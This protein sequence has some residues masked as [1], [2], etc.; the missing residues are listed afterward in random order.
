MVTQAVG[1]GGMGLAIRDTANNN[2]ITIDNCYFY[3]NNGSEKQGG[4]G[5][6]KVSIYAINKTSSPYSNTIII[7][8][9]NL[10]GNIAIYGAGTSLFA[11]SR[12]NKSYTNILIFSFC[13]WQYNFSPISAAVDIAPDV[14]QQTD[15][16]FH[17]RTSP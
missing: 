9:C 17:C 13:T 3:Y 14:R 6:I 16:N 5:G 15:T 12:L 1:G 11:S 2:K 4:G 10:I 8:K 7:N